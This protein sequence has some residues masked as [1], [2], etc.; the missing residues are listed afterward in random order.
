M[1]SS[2]SIKTIAAAMNAVRKDIKQPEKNAKNPFFKSDYVTLE[3]VVDAIDK[4]LPKGFSYTQ[5]VASEGN[6]VSVSTI[7]MSD[8]GE[9]IQFEPLTMPVAKNDAQ[10]FGSAETYARRYSLSAIFG[11]TSDLDDDGNKATKSAPK[12]QPRKQTRT[13]RPANQKPDPNAKA[14]QDL[15]VRLKAIST[16]MKVAEKKLLVKAAGKAKVN[17]L[18]HMTKNDLS[19]LDH[20]LTTELMEFQQSQQK[21]DKATEA[22]DDFLDHLDVDA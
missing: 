4:A 2:E 8:S 7:L 14:K 5:E 16:E 22:G 12:E 6:Q 13:R 10:A 17:D 18:S 20:E 9:W 15:K 21:D 3:G 1:K 19:A 11:V